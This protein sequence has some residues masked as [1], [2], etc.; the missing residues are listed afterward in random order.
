MP[1]RVSNKIFNEIWT[2]N[3]QLFLAE[4]RFESTCGVELV[5][6]NVK[7]KHSSSLVML[8][9]ADTRCKNRSPFLTPRLK[10]D[11]HMGGLI[12]N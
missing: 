5:N 6:A 8:Q 4:C 10:N 12:K 7:F 11:T 9:V 3:G 2:Q 1:H